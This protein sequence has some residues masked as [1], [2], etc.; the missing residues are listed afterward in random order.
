MG[1]DSNEFHAT[2]ASL[3]Q[4]DAS[5]V[6]ELQPRGI[7]V[8]DLSAQRSPLTAVAALLRDRQVDVLHTHGLLADINGRIAGRLGSGCAVVSTIHDSPS[9]YALTLGRA[10]G[11]LALAAQVF[12]FPCTHAIVM[13]AGSIGEAYRRIAFGA[14]RNRTFRTIHNGVRDCY[15]S[16][17]GRQD[18]AAAHGLVVGAVG[19]LTP[20]KGFDVLAEAAARLAP[21]LRLVEYVVAGDGEARP[22][23]QSQLD[24]LGL[25][26]AFRLAG[27]RA[28]I[29]DLLKGIDIFVLPSLDECLPLAVLEAMSAGKPVIASDVGGVSE[30]VV[31]EQTG[32]LVPPGDV[33]ALAGAIR[34][35]V[36]DPG[37][38]ERLGAA[39]RQRYLKMFTVER[40]VRQYAELYNELASRAARRHG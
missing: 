9:M 39:A 4:P 28:D 21:V 31:P 32:I 10:R 36:E 19:R 20:R 5:L 40:M 37:L 3:Y 29:P 27:A 16:E 11:A 13:V 22:Q 25:Q 18:E 24:Q 38:R 1:L 8:I 15:L 23:L 33:D 26:R 34:R 17:R 30:A 12:T 2:V 14:W 7:D 35:L 6:A